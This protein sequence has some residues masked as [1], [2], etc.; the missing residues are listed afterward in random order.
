LRSHRGTRRVGPAPSSTTRP[1]NRKHRPGRSKMNQGAARKGG[2]WLTRR[3]AQRR[4]GL[5]LPLRSVPPAGGARRCHDGAPVDGQ[6]GIVVRGRRRRRTWWCPVAVRFVVDGAVV[7]WWWCPVPWVVV[8]PA[9]V[10]VV[11][12][13]RWTTSRSPSLLD[14]DEG[15]RGRLVGRG[16]LLRTCRRSGLAAGCHHRSAPVG[17]V[18][19]RVCEACPGSTR[20]S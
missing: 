13:P 4:A 14:G 6:L 2:R 1:A 3:R 9:D 11:V 17:A 7:S 5:H 10:D 15:R 20:R 18:R 12:V 16:W 8:A 19:E